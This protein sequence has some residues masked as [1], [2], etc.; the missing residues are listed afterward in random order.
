MFVTAIKSKRL[1]STNK[2]LKNIKRNNISL[3]ICFWFVFS[4]TNFF[5]LCL[6]QMVNNQAKNSGGCS[7]KIPDP[8]ELIIGVPVVHISPSSQSPLPLHFPRHHSLR[9]RKKR[10]RRDMAM[11]REFRPLRIKLYFD[12]VSIS[13]LS[14]EKQFYI[15]ASQILL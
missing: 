15:N 8:E 3:L 13:P 11:G 7:Y 5:I 9:A 12:P 6:T 1:I 2:R 4:T 14:P 10:F